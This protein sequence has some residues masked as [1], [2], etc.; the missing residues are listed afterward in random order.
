MIKEVE[1]AIMAAD[2]ALTHLTAAMDKLNSAS[3][4]GIFDMFGGG[5]FATYIKR[6]KMKDAQAEMEKAQNA[7]MIFNRELED[8]QNMVWLIMSLITSLWIC[9]CRGKYPMHRTKSKKQSI[10]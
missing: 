10:R 4:W 2:N 1:E 5:V 9:L 7:L 6:S 3:G 8:V